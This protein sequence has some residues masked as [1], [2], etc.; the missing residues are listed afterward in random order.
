MVVNRYWRTGVRDSMILYVYILNEE[1]V[2][3]LRTVVKIL[4]FLH[5]SL[6]FQKLENQLLKKMH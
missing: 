1:I 4:F 6:E 5:I 3:F 2:H